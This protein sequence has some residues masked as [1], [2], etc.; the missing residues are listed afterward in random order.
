MT[1]SPQSSSPSGKEPWL[2]VNLSTILPG[3][4]QIYSGQVRKGWLLVFSYIVLL[5][6][7]LLS[8]LS[9]IGN[10]L[11]GM[12]CFLSIPILSLWNLFDAHYS[13]RIAN[14]SEFE[15]LR[16]RGKDPWLAV[17]LSRISIRLNHFY[18]VGLGHFY[19]GK[20]IWGALFLFLGFVSQSI[21]EIGIFMLLMVQIFAAH[22]VYVTTPARRDLDK[23]RLLPILIVLIFL[24]FLRSLLLRNQFEA[25]YIPAS[26][27][28]PT[29]QI[30]DRVI[31]NKFIYRFQDPQ[32]GDLVVFQPTQTLR[33]EHYKD[34]FIKR[35]IGL[36]GEKVEIKENQVYINE[37]KLDE[38]YIVQSLDRSWEDPSSASGTSVDVCK[39]KPPY[40]TQQ[41][42][43]NPA[44]WEAI[45]PPNN[46]L[47]MGDNRNN[48]YDSR[49]W[50][51]VPR[52]NLIGKVDKRWWPLDRIGNID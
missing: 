27:M 14:S 48:S 22:H 28:T 51:T 32:R 13:A 44:V 38:P 30:N 34:A 33:E 43:S 39:T 25:R 35:I 49:C 9:S 31:V 52:E 4:G 36:P 5:S 41:K 11:L 2:A 46:Y 15:E 37:Q 17:F 3:I 29:L 20:Y 1:R 18:L 7:G 19:I 12:G 50:G 45:V 26:S 16:K 8:L 10:P 21:S 23:K 6:F 47:V 24:P 42:G 40:F